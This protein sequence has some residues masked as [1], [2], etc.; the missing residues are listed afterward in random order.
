MP[1]FQKCKKNVWHISTRILTQDKDNCTKKGSDGHHSVGAHLQGGTFLRS[2]E[3]GNNTRLRKKDQPATN[4]EYNGL[5]NNGD[6]T[7][8]EMLAYAFCMVK[9][10]SDLQLLNMLW[11]ILSPQLEIAIHFAAQKLY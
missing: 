4:I 10:K 5:V 11:N 1:D 3:R 6:I 7:A 9:L 8:A 2:L